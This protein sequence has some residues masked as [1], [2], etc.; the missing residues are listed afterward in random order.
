MRKPLF[1]LPKMKYTILLFL[2]CLAQVLC[3]Q[4]SYEFTFVKSESKKIG[5]LIDPF[6]KSLFTK[7]YDLVFQGINKWY[8][9]HLL[10]Q[11]TLS[12]FA[13]FDSI[14]HYKLETLC[15]N[16]FRDI[17]QFVVKKKFRRYELIYQNK[18]Y[19]F[20]KLGKKN[21]AVELILPIQFC[22]QEKMYVDSTKIE[23]VIDDYF[24]LE[25]SLELY[26]PIEYYSKKIIDNKEIDFRLERFLFTID[27]I[28]PVMEIS[29]DDGTLGIKI[30][31]IFPIGHKKYV[32]DH[33][34]IVTK[35]M[36]ISA[37]E[38]SDVGYMKNHKVIRPDLCDSTKITLL[39]F[40]GS[41]CGPCQ[42]LTP[43][44]KRVFDDS[45]LTKKYFIHAIQ[46][47]S[48]EEDYRHYIDSKK[49]PWKTTLDLKNDNGRNT[50]RSQFNVPGFPTMFVIDAN[51]VIL[52]RLDKHVFE[53][54]EYLEK[55]LPDS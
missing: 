1:K 27:E 37:V 5:T 9:L 23:L 41:W 49:I 47:E 28:F 38:E 34:D 36:K 50:L 32:I 22:Q 31:D 51:G 29:S 54:L 44:L 24:Y 14:Y 7:E 6:E 48:S 53:I 55:L 17:H 46:Y 15:A 45:A 8:A 25:N 52:E 26:I 30:S 20:Q 18:S 16:G 42:K 33:F 2:L 3:S 12:E 19:S 11:D 4:N 39:Y 40:T 21:Y 35:Q 10:G 43:T 13:T